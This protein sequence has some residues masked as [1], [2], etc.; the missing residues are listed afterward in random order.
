MKY[1][2]K[3]HDLDDVEVKRLY[4]DELKSLAYI[5]EVM[6]VGPLQIRRCLENNGVSI[7]KKNELQT[8][9]LK[10]LYDDDAL[11]EK[12]REYYYDLGLT[13]VQC[14]A[15]LRINGSTLLRLM[16]YWGMDRR[17]PHNS[18]DTKFQDLPADQ[19]ISD[20]NEKKMSLKQVAIKNETSVDSIV[21][22]I[23][24]RG[25]KCRSVSES[26]KMWWDEQRK[27]PTERH[28][29]PIVEEETP[30]VPLVD[31]ITDAMSLDEKIIEMRKQGNHLVQD[32]AKALDTDTVYV[33]KVLLKHKRL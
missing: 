10:E 4:V 20:Y 11:R 14:G 29:K 16:E 6:G 25:L 27:N 28:P 24:S 22:V 17:L 9:R 19:I 7:R 31:T 32:I 33:A 18:P 21:K 2:S 8:L 23:K 13:I 1:R 12:V 5:A 30:A 26:K 3:F 15:R